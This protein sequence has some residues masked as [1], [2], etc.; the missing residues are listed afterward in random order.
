MP[1]RAAAETGTPPSYTLTV[2]VRRSHPTAAPPPADTSPLPHLRW[3][4]AHGG[5]ALAASA[6]LSQMPV[7]RDCYH[8]RLAA[9]P[10]RGVCLLDLPGVRARVRVRVRVKDT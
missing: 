6:F 1:A 7:L 10:V 9:C 3:V 5:M 8:R 2:S 4:E